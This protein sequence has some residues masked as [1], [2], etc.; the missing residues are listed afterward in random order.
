MSFPEEKGQGP[1]PS[2]LEG[3]TP[4]VGAHDEHHV[5]SHVEHHTEHH[6]EHIHH[7]GAAAEH[8]NYSHEVVYADMTQPS[9]AQSYEKTGDYAIADKTSLGTDEEAGNVD[10][11][12]DSNDPNRPTGFVRMWYR[13]L[14]APLHLFIWLVFTA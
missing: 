11:A 9:R 10:R 14:R 1:S 13:R 12:R 5:E 2:A 7:G 4:K 3:A 6:H 8:A